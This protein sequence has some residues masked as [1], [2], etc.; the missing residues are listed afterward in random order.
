MTNIRYN[1]VSVGDQVAYCGQETD[2]VSAFLML[3]PWFGTHRIHYDYKWAREEGFDDIVIMGGQMYAWFEKI[4]SEWAG[5]PGCVKT[6]NFRHHSSAVA[7][8]FLQ[9]SAVVAEKVDD[10]AAGGRVRCEISVT[11]EDGTKVLSGDFSVKL[12]A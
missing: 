10:Q 3:L 11:K 7:G 12:P 4:A 5:D 9:L 1:E 8:E 6:M 2:N